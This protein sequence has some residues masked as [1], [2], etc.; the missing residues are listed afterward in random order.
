MNLIG[1][2]DHTVRELT[3]VSAGGVTK[4]PMGE[5]II[6]IY[7]TADMTID[8]MTILSAGQLEAFGCRIDDRQILDSPGA[9]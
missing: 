8:S 6:I 9:Y 5:I 4:T 1:I 3:I 2:D 7:Q